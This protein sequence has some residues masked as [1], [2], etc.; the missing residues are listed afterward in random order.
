M[1]PVTAAI[2]GALSAE[3]R[4]GTQDA[5]K[6]AVADAYHGHCHG[7]SVT[8]IRGCLGEIYHAAAAAMSHASKA[9]ARERRSVCR[10][11]RWRWTLKAL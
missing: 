5:V 1:E 7:K 10:E 11:I 2:L 6:A 8:T 3:A 4:S 9:A